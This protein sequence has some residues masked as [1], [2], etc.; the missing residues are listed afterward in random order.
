MWEYLHMVLKHMTDTFIGKFYYFTVKFCCFVLFL[1]L[2][3]YFS[4]NMHHGGKWFIDNGLRK[5]EGGTVTEFDKCH[6]NM[7]NMM[8][9]EGMMMQIQW[10]HGPLHFW[11]RPKDK[12]LNDG[13]VL[14]GDKDLLSMFD[15]VRRKRYRKVEVY[16]DLF[17]TFGG[18]CLELAVVG[19]PSQKTTIKHSTIAGPKLK[20]CIIEELPDDADVV[21]DVRVSAQPEDYVMSKAALK[22]LEEELADYLEASSGDSEQH[23]DE[24]FMYMPDIEE[25]SEDNSVENLDNDSSGDSDSSVQILENVEEI[26]GIFGE[27]GFTAEDNPTEAHIEKAQSPT[28]SPTQTRKR[29]RQT[30]TLS[31]PQSQK[32]PRQTLTNSPPQTRK[33]VRQTPIKSSPQTR[34]KQA[35]T[36]SETL[37]QSAT[38]TRK[39]PTESPSGTPSQTPIQTRNRT[40]QTSD[41]FATQSGTKTPTKKPYQTPIQTRNRTP[42]P[43]TTLQPNQAPKHQ[44]KNPPKHPSKPEI[45]H[46]KPG[47]NLQPNQPPKHPSKPPPAHPKAITILLPNHPPKPPPKPE[48]PHPKPEKPHPKPDPNSLPDH[49]PKHLPKPHPKPDQPHPKPG[50]KLH[51]KHLTKPPVV[52]TILLPNHP[53]KHLPKHPPKLKKP[54]PNPVTNLLPNHPPKYPPIYICL[55]ACKAGFK[56]CRPIIGL[57]GCFL[58]GYCRVGVSGTIQWGKRSLT[59]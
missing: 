41:H 40:P 39:L 37:P 54:H 52:V 34:K 59:S 51:P 7:F 24:L 10:C 35:P 5:Y 30:P 3:M 26:E 1:L 2:G 56:F 13:F 45:K 12:L 6:S 17:G 49:P 42:Q 18:D 33:R 21:V 11:F 31:P 25:D 22:N 48:K 27:V 14:K 53:P 15:D 58:K 44:L 46:P 50:P 19:G 38:Q 16:V 9:L 57:D 43:M 20:R 36:V 28:K 29:P 32:R 23:V 8:E 4:V 55:V 47:P